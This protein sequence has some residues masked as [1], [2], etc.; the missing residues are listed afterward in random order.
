MVVYKRKVGDYIFE[1]LNTLLMIFL[2]LITVYP[3]LYVLFAA[4]SDPDE[5]MAYGGI[6]LYPLSPN[7]ESFKAVINNPNIQIG[8]AH[9]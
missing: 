7:L 5:F 9:V 3:F 8:R 4:L 2:M 1:S 6:L